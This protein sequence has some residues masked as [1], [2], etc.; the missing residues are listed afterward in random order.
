MNDDEQ[1][2]PVEVKP[3]IAESRINFEK[4][5]SQNNQ[6]EKDSLPAYNSSTIESHDKSENQIQKIKTNEK[7]NFQALKLSLIIAGLT[8]IM[9]TVIGFFTLFYAGIISI[10]MPLVL[11]GFQ[12][13]LNAFLIYAIWRMM[14]RGQKN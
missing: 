4:S 10:T 5:L 9:L 8:S 3:K 14:T 12:G 2:R 6:F 1:T 7:D 13:S 11:M